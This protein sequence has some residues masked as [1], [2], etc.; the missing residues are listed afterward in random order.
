MNKTELIKRW[1]SK[2]GNELLQKVIHYLNNGKSL[3][4]IEGLEKHNDRFDLRGA[5]LSVIKKENNI[6]VS[7]HSLSLKTG[8]LK[9]NHIVLESVDFSFGDISNSY[10]K[11]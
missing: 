3:Y 2:V 11:K 4:N 7:G 10:L 1:Q 9:L 8:S 6:E 5:K